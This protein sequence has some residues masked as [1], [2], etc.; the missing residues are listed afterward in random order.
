M[1][2]MAESFA[3][4]PGDLDVVYRTRGRPEAALLDELRVLAADRGLRLHLVTGK[5]A[6]P[7]ADPPGAD[8]LGPEAL[9][10]LVPDAAERDVYLCGPTGLM[11]RARSALL[12]LGTDP[13]RIHF[14]LFTT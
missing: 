14:E 2:A 11:E 9:R 3:Y 6:A 5:R 4:G 8:P 12:A 7:G 10:R 1:R 13:A